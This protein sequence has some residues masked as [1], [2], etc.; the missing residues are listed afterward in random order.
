MGKYEKTVRNTILVMKMESICG[1]R[2]QIGYRPI[3]GYSLQSC[4][5]KNHTF[6][7]LI[8]FLHV[9]TYI[10]IAKKFHI[11]DVTNWGTS[12]ADLTPC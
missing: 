3:L 12:G 6:Y 10:K 2:S 1:K 7:F 5:H 9:P 8:P 4:K 11:I